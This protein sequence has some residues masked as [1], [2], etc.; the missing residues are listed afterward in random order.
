MGEMEPGR[1]KGETNSGTR[2][3][4]SGLRHGPF[5]TS[6]RG[7]ILIGAAGTPMGNLAHRWGTSEVCS[8]IVLVTSGAVTVLPTVTGAVPLE[9]CPCS[10]IVL[11]ETKRK[12]KSVRE[13]IN[14]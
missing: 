11:L 6:V 3:T 7:T 10:M 12:I 13:R 8:S 1:A 9:Q 2:G 4:G 14:I 5:G